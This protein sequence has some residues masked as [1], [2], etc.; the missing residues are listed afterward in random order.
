M[1]IDVNARMRLYAFNKLVKDFS[2]NWLDV[3]GGQGIFSDFVNKKGGF[4]TLVD[5]DVKALSTANKINENVCYDE[6]DISEG[7]PYCDNV[8]DKVMVFEVLEHLKEPEK[9]CFEVKRVLKK[10]G[11]LY[12]SVPLVGFHK[13]TPELVKVK[14]HLNLWSCDAWISLLSSVGFRVVNRIWLYKRFGWWIQNLKW[15]FPFI[16]KYPSFLFGWLSRLD[17]LFVC[18]GRGVLLECVKL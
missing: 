4:V 15:R 18:E 12:V 16:N 13:F 2:G 8:F 11:F 7:L 14:G 10:G 6:F 1:I 9:V 5:R 3:G 17:D